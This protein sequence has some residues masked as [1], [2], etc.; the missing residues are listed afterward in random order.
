MTFQDLL[1]I[2]LA[3]YELAMSEPISIEPD[4]TV[5]LGSDEKRTYPDMDPI[6]ETVQNMKAGIISV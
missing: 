3:C 2:R 6:L 1:D 4:G 5:W